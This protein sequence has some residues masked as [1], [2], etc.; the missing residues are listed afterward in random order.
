MKRYNEQNQTQCNPAKEQLI[1]PS[2]DM[3]KK[4]CMGFLTTE[5]C[6]LFVTAAKAD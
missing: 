3:S 2:G 1:Q 6:K 5:L 4:Q